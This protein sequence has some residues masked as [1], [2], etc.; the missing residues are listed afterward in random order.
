MGDDPTVALD[1]PKLQAMLQEIAA[2]KIQLP[3]FQREWKWDDERI[4]ALLA[5]VTLEYPLGVVMT[6]ET[7]GGKPPFK[8]RTLAG[9]EGGAGHVPELLLLDGQQRLTSLF[10][11]LFLEQPVET[12]DAR[13]N[14]LRRW[15]YV[16]IARAIEAGA[17]RDEAIVSVP[18]DRL[19]ICATPRVA[20][21]TP[22]CSTV[23]H[24]R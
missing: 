19:R 8:A 15:Y 3:D 23:R 2:G 14:K 11:A 4:R 13:G 1:G 9:A 20:Y 7:G 17:D 6:L 12:T 10:Q 16:N 21:H 18:E 22:S 5:T 24:H